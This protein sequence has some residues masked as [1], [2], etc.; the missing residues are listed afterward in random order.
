MQI[1]SD[2]AKMPAMKARALEEAQDLRQSYDNLKLEV[3]MLE[4]RLLLQ[5][6]ATYMNETNPEIKA[7]VESEE[8]LYKLRLELIIKEGEYKKKEIQANSFDDRFTSAKRLAQLEIAGFNNGVY[9]K[10]GTQ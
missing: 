2:L 3:K 1:A 10:G 5:F 8:S 9:V 4:A 6:K 7:R